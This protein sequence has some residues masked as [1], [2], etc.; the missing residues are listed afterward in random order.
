M[1]SQDL[2]G[3]LLVY[4][5]VNLLGKNDTYTI[6]GL[7]RV[8]PLLVLTPRSMLWLDLERHHSIIFTKI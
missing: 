5:E 1:D 3:F 8:G 7:L 2:Y 6:N 4:P